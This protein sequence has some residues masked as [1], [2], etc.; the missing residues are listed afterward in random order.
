MAK[1]FNNEEIAL[2]LEA[3]QMAA[4]RHESEARL[5]RGQAMTAENFARGRAMLDWFKSQG[6]PPEDAIEVMM[7]AVAAKIGGWA[8]DDDDLQ[9][10]LQAAI[11]MLRAR[12]EFTYEATKKPRALGE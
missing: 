6:I 11:D 9:K 4:S 2:V 8:N 12:A 5:R 1:V 3:L 10:S 7:I